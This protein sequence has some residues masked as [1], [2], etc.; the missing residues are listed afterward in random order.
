MAESPSIMLMQVPAPG[1]VLLQSIRLVLV[2]VVAQDHV[3]PGVVVDVLMFV[4]VFFRKTIRRVPHG[5]RLFFALT[6]VSK[7]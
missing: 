7:T 1:S 6:L 4:E 5:A 3:A 2:A